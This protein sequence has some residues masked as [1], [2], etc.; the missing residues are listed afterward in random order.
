MDRGGWGG[1]SEPFDRRREKLQAA[2]RHLERVAHELGRTVPTW[3]PELFEENSDLHRR[4]KGLNLS[5]KP[6][7]VTA[8]HIGLP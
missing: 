1:R 7:E 5:V 3:V 6:G 4:R 8:L 2:V